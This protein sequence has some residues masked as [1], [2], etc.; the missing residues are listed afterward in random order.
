MTQLYLLPET[1]QKS[2][3]GLP[4]G[5]AQAILHTLQCEPDIVYTGERAAV[6]H[7]TP[8]VIALRENALIVAWFYDGDPRGEE[9]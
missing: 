7:L 1:V 2:C 3:L 4:L 5:Q 8:R 9:A 6:E